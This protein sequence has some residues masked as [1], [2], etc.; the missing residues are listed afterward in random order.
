MNKHAA[1]MDLKGNN[2][3]KVAERL[4]LFREDHPNSKTE[5]AF[6]NDVD[7]TT[8]FTV[9]VW[10]DKA[11][12]IELMKAGVTDKEA[13]RSSSDAN[14]TS[15]GT[16]GGK[17]KDFEKLETVALGRALGMLGYLASGEIASS[18]EMQ[19][20]L[21]EKQAKVSEALASIKACDSL[22]ALQ[23]LYMSLG[24]LKLNT[25]VIEAKDARKAELK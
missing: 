14:G 5:T 23:K 16:L 11:D 17:E 9:W 18:E 10:K 21:Q 25:A 13:L 7:G 8:A 1:T 22:E 24:K 20:F 6:E 4:K 15:K 3:A 12:L 2:Y 19:E